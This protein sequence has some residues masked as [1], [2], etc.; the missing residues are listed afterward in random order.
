MGSKYKEFHKHLRV[1]DD[2]KNDIR[3]VSST[4][5]YVVRMWGVSQSVILIN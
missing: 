3:L 2:E 4:I 5:D 1:D